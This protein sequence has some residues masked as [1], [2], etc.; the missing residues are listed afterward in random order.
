MKNDYYINMMR[1]L[2]PIHVLLLLQML[3]CP[4]FNEDCG[5]Y[6]GEWPYTHLFSEL[7]EALLNNKTMMN[8][9]RQIFLGTENVQIFFS[10]QLE[11]VNGTDLSSSCDGD[12]YYNST[13]P[14]SFDTFCPSNSSDYKWKLCNIPEKYGF[15]SMEMIYTTQSRSKIQSEI[16]KRESE[17]EKYQIDVAIAWLSLLHGNVLSPLIYFVPGVYF[18]FDGSD[19]YEGGNDYFYDWGN[20][21]TSLTLV[22]ERLDCNPSLPLTQCALS[23]LFSWVSELVK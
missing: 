9:L 19:Y 13:P 11:A 23:E 20:Y 1:R 8:L 10:V 12:P 5:G 15:D 3:F 22:M 7:E 4:G 2:P 6:I 17:I 21:Y 18:D 14:S 16:S